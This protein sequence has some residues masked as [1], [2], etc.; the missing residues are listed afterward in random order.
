[1]KKV[2][3]AAALA[4]L[5]A[6]SALAADLPPLT[7]TK[8]PLMTPALNWTGWYVGLSAGG[9]WAHIDTQ[10]TLP[11]AFAGVNVPVYGAASSPTLDPSGFVGG[12]QIG[13]NYQAGRWLFG[14]EADIQALSD[15][16][17]IVTSITPPGSPTL[18]AV[19]SVSANWLA[20]VRGRLG[21]TAGNLLLYGTG[22][23]AVADLKY[24]QNSIYSPCGPGICAE[25]ASISST[26]AGWAAG[27]GFEYAMSRNWSVKG[28]YLYTQ[29]KGVSTSGL[30]S[31]FFTTFL[32][33][34]GNYGINIARAGVN[35]RF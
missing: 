2:L 25:S 28:E 30:E 26:K 10:T 15:K 29:F 12:G 8:A 16:K 7:Y 33:N 1:M 22:G 32:H 14:I 19:T 13:Y 4:G 27:G 31:A 5:S 3:V 17:S 23:L 24:A 18:T 20:T 34:T 35:Y 21:I 6:T 11:F 9:T